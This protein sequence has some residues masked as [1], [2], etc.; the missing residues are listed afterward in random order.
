[1]TRS[2]PPGAISWPWNTQRKGA[3]RTPYWARFVDRDT[4]QRLG[5]LN[6]SHSNWSRDAQAVIGLNVRERRIER[7]SRKTRRV[8]TVVE[9]ADMPLVS[10][11]HA[12]WMGLAPDGSPLVV[13]DRSTRDL[14]TFDWEAP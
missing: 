7:W 2:A 5:D 1:C 11:L 6:L 9:V 10:P 12:P 4:W 3:P 14:Y 13:R 8:E